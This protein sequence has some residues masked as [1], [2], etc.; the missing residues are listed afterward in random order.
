[1]QKSVLLKRFKLP[2]L[3]TNYVVEP[4]KQLNQLAIEQE[5]ENDFIWGKIP[6]GKLPMSLTLTATSPRDP[7]RMKHKSGWVS[8]PM[9]RQHYLSPQQF[10]TRRAPQ[11]IVSPLQPKEVK[12][13][14]PPEFLALDPQKNMSNLWKMDA[15]VY[16]QSDDDELPEGAEIRITKPKQM[17]KVSL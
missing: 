8:D 10:F 1:M 16:A 5:A 7:M 13:R 3:L 14:I 6:N 4:A 17:I 9:G 15:R 2:N 11:Q 12:V